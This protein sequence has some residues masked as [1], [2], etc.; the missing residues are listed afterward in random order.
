MKLIKYISLTLTISALLFPSSRFNLSQGQ[1]KQ[2]KYEDGI[3]SDFIY[4]IKKNQDGLVWVASQSGVSVIDGINYIRYGTSD[5]LPTSDITKI[6]F[7]ENKTYVSTLDKGIYVFNDNYFEKVEQVKGNNISFMDLVGDQIFISNKIENILFNGNSVTHMGWGFPKEEIIDILVDDS[8]IWYAS[9]NAIIKKNGDK[10]QSYKINF[11]NKKIKI[12]CIIK[13]NK[14]VLLGTNKGIWSWN[15]KILKKLT[16]NPINVSSFESSLEGQILVG[17]TKGIFSFYDDKIAP[18]ETTSGFNKILLEV[19]IK[20]IHFISEHE[21][22]YSTF[23]QGILLHDPSSFHT[24]GL[25][26]GL[27]TG[28]SIHDLV[29]D[30]SN[31]YVGTNNGLYI[32]SSV[33][34]SI[35]HFTKAS[36]LPTNKVLGIDIGSK[37]IAYLATTKGLSIFDGMSFT[38][39]KRGDGLPSNLILSVLVDSENPNI[40]WL[41][42]RKGITKFEGSTFYNYSKQDGLASNIVQDIGQTSDGELVLACYNAGIVMFDK[43]SNFTLF[44]SGL[45]TKKVISVAVGKANQIYVG[46]ENAGIGMLFDNQFKMV[47]TSDGLSHNEVYSLSIINNEIW[48][49][50]FGGGVSFSTDNYWS[51]INKSD[52]I[53]GNTVGAITSINDGRIAIGSKTGVTV[54][55]PSSEK[56]ILDIE[57]ISSATTDIFID[58]NQNKLIKGKPSERFSLYLNPLYYTPNA[59]TIKYRTRMVLGSVKSEWSELVSSPT[60]EYTDGYKESMITHERSE[61]GTYTLQ[62]QA[63]DNKLNSSDIVS[64]PFKITQVWYLNPTTAIPFWLSIVSLFCFSGYTFM[65]FRKQKIETKRLKEAE[66]KRQNAELEEA[67]EFQQSLLPDKMPDSKLY[68]V[69]GYQKTASE[70]GGDYFDF[71]DKKSG[72]IIAICGDA[73]GHGLTSGNVVAI[74]KTA[75]SSISTEDPVTILDILNKTLLKMKIGLNRMCLN[76]ADL[77]EDKIIFSSAGM[78]PAYFYS[79]KDKKLK[80]ILVGALPLGSFSLSM[81]SS[82]EIE[83]KNSGD[84][85]IMMSD[86]LPEAENNDGEMVGYEKTEETIKSLINL[87]SE[88]IKNGLVDLCD[89]WIKGAE[90][91]DDMT[92]VIIKKK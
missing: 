41:G 70:V 92:F 81:H 85:F 25:E 49:G 21:I 54:F 61:I 5:G 42:S 39:Y 18:L 52:G 91:Q 43:K 40:I 27:N 2:I 47:N 20:D 46:T 62:V 50:T 83:F 68:D 26:K 37:G 76:I 58:R 11:N 24:I 89:S 53:L 73:T 13:N 80:E 82:E 65:N 32:I 63:I 6:I 84:A 88:E 29:Y 3:T 33:D 17:S 87:S 57:K 59:S 9:K 1:W 16:V 77:K 86:G 12:Q 51:T 75:L 55:T 34:Y 10:Y 36:G 28:G 60:I 7:H 71:I 45:T 14:N 4:D 79:A 15:D 56:I 30:N 78:P 72:R 38:N 31:I 48:A 23:G 19:S 67:R 64:I 90:L 8:E 66:I 74:T 44:D 35:K 22:W 69:V